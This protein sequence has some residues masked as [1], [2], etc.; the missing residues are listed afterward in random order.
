MGDTSNDGMP[1]WARALMDQ[2]AI[3]VKQLNDYERMMDN[4]LRVIEGNRIT[5]KELKSKMD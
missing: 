3:L 4:R 2:N 5:R 1:Q